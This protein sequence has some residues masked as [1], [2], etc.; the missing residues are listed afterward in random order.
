MFPSSEAQFRS[1]VQKPS[2]EAQF[3]SPVQKPGFLKKPGF[4]RA[5]SECTGSECHYPL[6]TAGWLFLANAA[7]F[8]G[9][10]E[11]H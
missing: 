10:V 9:A 7:L 4:S 1:P 11:L 2:S 6:P 8:I 5:G 3:R